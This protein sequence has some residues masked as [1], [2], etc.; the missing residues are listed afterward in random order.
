M[1]VILPL[2]HTQ[3]PI[4]TLYSLHSYHMPTNMSTYKENIG[5]YTRLHTHI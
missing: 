3:T 4:R 1:N 5:S 2:K